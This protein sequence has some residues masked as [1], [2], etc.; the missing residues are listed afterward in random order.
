MNEIIDTEKGYVASLGLVKAVSWGEREREKERE[1][2]KERQRERE[3]KR[4]TVEI[5]FFFCYDLGF[6]GA[7]EECKMVKTRGI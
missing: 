7:N 2:V 3:R 4:K 6:Y 5:D 1:R